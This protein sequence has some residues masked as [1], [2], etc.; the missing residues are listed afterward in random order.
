MYLWQSVDVKCSIYEVIVGDSDEGEGEE[1]EVD[2]S[3]ESLNDRKT[4]NRNMSP[5]WRRT[6]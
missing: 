1:G 4:R 5:D 2:V 3:E 6:R